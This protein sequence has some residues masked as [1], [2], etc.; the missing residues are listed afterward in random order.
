MAAA[1]EA[2][3]AARSGLKAAKMSA[4]A[5]QLQLRSREER[6]EQLKTRLNTASSNKEY[7][8]FK[9]QIAAD[10]QAN[11]V[12]S[13]EI[14]EALEELDELEEKLQQRV[15]EQA[16]REAEHQRM[17]EQVEAKRV[18]LEEDLKR[19]LA[20]LEEAEQQL[21][22]DLLTDYRRLVASRGEEALAPVEGESCGGCYTR[23]TAQTMNRLYLSQL[24]RCPSCGALL[25][26]PEDRT[27]R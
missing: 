13:D 16:Q 21:P 9:E 17:V 6:V 2:T 10:E 11:S 3:E 7:Q 25:Y 12:L 22:A 18:E 26:L 23:L 19:V 27:V 14:L 8:T 15:E 1:R 4:D 24:A 5:K 20:E